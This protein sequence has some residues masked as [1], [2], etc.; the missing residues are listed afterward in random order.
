MNEYGEMFYGTLP[1][2]TRNFEQ[3]LSG[4]GRSLKDIQ[5]GISFYPYD[6]IGAPVDIANLALG[7]IGLGSE[8]PVLGNDYLRNIA[9]SLG[10]AQEPTGSAVENITRFSS[11]FINPVA[12]AKTVNKL[13]DLVKFITKPPKEVPYGQNFITKETG[14]ILE[15]TPTRSPEIGQDLFGIGSPEGIY[16]G[17]VFS[18]R[19]G[20]QTLYGVGEQE[21]NR[22]IQ[23][24]LAQPNTN[25][26]FQIANAYTNQ[27]F[28]QPY[29]IG[30]TLPE[31]SLAKQSGIGRAYEIAA[32]FPNKYPKDKIFEGYLNDAEYG[33]I[34]KSLGIKNYDDLLQKSYKQLEKETTDQFSKLPVKM[35][36]HG[37]NLNY[38]DSSEM[39]K[40]V[41]GHNHLTVFRGGDK[42]EF[43]NKVDQ[44]TGLNSN[45]QFRAVHDYF[46]H[47]IKG[48]S[49]GS[50]GEEIAWASHQQMFSPLARIAMTS[51]TRGQNSFVN[52]TPINAELYTAM[53]Q[54]R[55]TQ[56]DAQKAG[57]IETVKQ[58]T[59]TL[60]QL[61]QEW[62]YAKQ[63]SVVLPVEF[64]KLDFK[65]GM[66]NYLIDA[67]P[68]KFGAEETLT[69]FGKSPDIG[70]LDPQMYGSGIRGEEMTRLKETEQAIVPRSYAYR[71]EPS[72][73]QPE[74]GLGPY[75]YQ[76]KIGGLYD[77]GQDPEKLALLSKT[78]N[79][80]S[81]LTSY[82]GIENQPQ[83]LTD[84]ERLAMQYGYRGLLDPTKAIL[85]KQ[86]PVMRVR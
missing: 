57:D 47:A 32:E 45:E 34:I 25:R 46:G 70:L 31:S 17:T 11:G 66:P 67:V 74:P 75:V 63:A 26:A 54:V 73:I 60:R 53:E 68:P 28:S 52:Y 15:V 6:L 50:K 38:L 5:R 24:I 1:P 37:G 41:I 44:S 80:G 71:G 49:F 3:V 58:A 13:E 83:Q 42:H 35:S 65:G 18:A 64:T 43:L 7:T 55:K 20:G 12:G 23:S 78:R 85:F 51:E 21:A 69:H 9:K 81:Y 86:T 40:D 30:F 29:N 14:G 82:G 84:L 10:L 72:S 76:T 56:R 33:P 48:N 77:I 22:Q 16:P 62:G 19:G 4:V 8:R 2:D 36:F 61:G 79:T 59:E 27:N 39:L